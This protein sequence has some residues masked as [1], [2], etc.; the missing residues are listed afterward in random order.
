MIQIIAFSGK[1]QSGKTTTANHISSL[2]PNSIV[3]SHAAPLKAKIVEEFGLTFKD[4][5]DR[6]KDIISFGKNSM[7]IRELM[8]RVGR[9]YR[10]IDKDFWIKQL[11]KSIKP[12]MDAGNLI[13][14]DDLRYANEYAAL[15]NAGAMV[16][17]IYRP[18]VDLIDDPSETEL[19]HHDFNGYVTNDGTL[20][21][22][23]SRVDL[24]TSG[25][26]PSRPSAANT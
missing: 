7:T 10:E 26:L 21:Q 16:V 15:K 19:D 6:K 25:W 1:A 11:L 5:R 18:G 3:A 22:L 8:I 2:I 14:I 24:I 13:L 17:R 20:D 9:M 23:K 12:E 4:L